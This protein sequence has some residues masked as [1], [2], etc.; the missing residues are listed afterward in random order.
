MSETRDDLLIE[1]GTEELPPTALRELMTSFAEA[2]ADGLDQAGISRG[3]AQPYATPRR[4]AVHIPE[5]ALRQPDREIERLGPAV[6]AA[7]DSEGEPTRAAEGFARSCGVAV[8]ELVR[9][10]TE[11]GERLAYRGVEPG[12]ETA[13]LLPGII[14]HALSRLPIPKRMRWGDSDETFVRPAHWLLIKLGT[15]VVPARLLELDSDTYSRGHRFH[16]PDPLAIAHPRDYADTLRD[17]GRVL[18][19]FDQRREHIRSGVLDVARGDGGEAVIREPLLEEVTALVEWPVALSGGFD[20]DFLRVPEEALISSMEGHQR[21]FPVRGPDGRLMPR[22]VAVANIESRDPRQVIAGNERVIRPRLADAAFFWDQDRRTPL[23]E[24][25][26]GLASVVFQK[27]LGTLYDKSAR[28]AALARRFAGD[29]GIDTALAER[30]AW[31]AKADLLTEMVDE[32]PDLQGVMGRYYARE[33]GEPEA[34]CMALDEVYRPRSAGDHVAATPLGQ[35]L[36][37]AER[38]DTLVGIFAI[39]KAPRGAKDP[40][41]LRRA[42][43]GLAR[44]LLES[45]RDISLRELFAAAADNLPGG[46]DGD[47]QVGPVM[48]FTVERLRAWYLEQGLPAEVFAAVRALH[49]DDGPVASVVDFDRRVMACQR[50]L[51]RPEA[52]GLAEANK[53]I[54]NILRKAGIQGEAGVPDPRLLEN[55]EEHTLHEALGNARDAVER[56]VARGDY[57]TALEHLAGLAGPVDAFFEGVLVMAEDERVRD[58]RLALLHRLADAFLAVADISELP[59]RSHS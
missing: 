15:E 13:G 48:E 53:R 21:Y 31:L 11:K 44:T 1:L 22:F 9:V 41:G 59:G 7:F 4:L 38:A 42:A 33:D 49:G 29:F 16:H 51:E 55:P 47:A 46:L 12:S 6:A 20:E 25:V 26:E 10:E 19:D 24:R 58:N 39:G 32:F 52:A 23:A 18:A 50:F 35:L 36:A 27:A 54:R 37:V 40:F 3:T 5:V 14:G 2:V 45:Q 56:S 28:V 30:A 34:L 8:A 17:P 43:L 57:D